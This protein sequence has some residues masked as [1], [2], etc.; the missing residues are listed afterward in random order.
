MHQKIEGAL[1]RAQF[2]SQAGRRQFQPPD[3]VA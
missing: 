2:L 3:P 1:D